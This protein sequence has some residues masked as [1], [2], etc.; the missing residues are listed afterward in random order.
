MLSA[1]PFQQIQET[2]L[3]NPGRSQPIVAGSVC[4]LQAARTARIWRGARGTW[5]W[6]SLPVCANTLRDTHVPLCLQPLGPSDC[7]SHHHRCSPS[8]M[9][10]CPSWTPGKAGFSVHI[11]GYHHVMLD[12]SIYL[13]RC[14]RP[15]HGL[16][17][18]L[19]TDRVKVRS[20][21]HTPTPSLALVPSLLPPPPFSP[22]QGVVT[23]LLKGNQLFITRY[24]CVFHSG[25]INLD[26]L[27]CFL[28][29]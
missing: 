16:R 13:P 3:A 18:A 23:P 26:F 17:W 11:A 10:A 29:L 21:Q 25:T 9:C 20:L 14:P 12:P 19:G 1:I 7:C 15:R 2:I 8:F 5:S 28:A 22:G 24:T 6:T 27:K 4:A